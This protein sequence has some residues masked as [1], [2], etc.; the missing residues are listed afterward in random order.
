MEA[1]NLMGINPTDHR[2]TFLIGSIL[3]SGRR[4]R[5]YQTRFVS[6]SAH[7]IKGWRRWW[8]AGELLRRHGGAG[9]PAVESGLGLVR[10][11]P[12]KD[13]FAF[14]IVIFSSS[15]RRGHC[16]AQRYDGL[17]KSHLR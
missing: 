3:A 4:S 7:M 14:L 12:L 5:L 16:A 15:T 10:R 2:A 6:T 17:C 8:A 13:V 9:D 11:R 1:A